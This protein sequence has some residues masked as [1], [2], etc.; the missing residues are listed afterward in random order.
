MRFVKIFLEHRK[1]NESELRQ[2]IQKNMTQEM[3]SGLEYDD[4]LGRSQ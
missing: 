4:P 2:Y 3:I 1:V